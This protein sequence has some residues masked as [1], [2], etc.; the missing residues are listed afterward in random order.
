[1]FLEPIRRIHRDIHPGLLLDVL[2]GIE[3]LMAHCL[4]YLLASFLATQDDQIRTLSKTECCRAAWSPDGKLIAWTPDGK[5]FSSVAIW[6]VKVGK[7]VRSI[8]DDDTL[9]ALD[10]SPDSKLIATTRGA[11]FA[12]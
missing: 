6:D 10:F 3:V 7:V 5:N 1:M 8:K 9:P 12:V 11:K 4:S 2:C